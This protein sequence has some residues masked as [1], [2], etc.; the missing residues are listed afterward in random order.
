MLPGIQGD[1][2]IAECQQALAGNP[3]D[4]EWQGNYNGKYIWWHITVDPSYD[5]EGNVIGVS[6][7]ATDIT[8]RKLHEQHILAQNESL[9]SIAYIQSH[10]LRRPVA[11]ILGLANI[12]EADDYVFNKEDVEMLGRAANELD[13]KIRMIV[14]YSDEKG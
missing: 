4:C 8:E 1:R 5:T 9:K 10:E 7:N 13:A 6:F 2:F 12:M 11:S 3:I 14:G